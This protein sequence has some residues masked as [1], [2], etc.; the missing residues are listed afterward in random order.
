MV[1]SVRAPEDRKKIRDQREW[2]STSQTSKSTEYANDLYGFRWAISAMQ[3]GKK[4]EKVER[5]R[6][7]K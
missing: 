4:R 7:I 6:G 3:E 5:A 1:A 2:R